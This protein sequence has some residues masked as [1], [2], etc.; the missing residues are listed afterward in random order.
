M[1]RFIWILSLIW[2][3]SYNLPKS[4]SR[5]HLIHYVPH[6]KFLAIDQMMLQYC[7][8]RH[9]KRDLNEI[10]TSDK[11]QVAQTKEW[12]RSDMEIDYC[13]YFH[14]MMLTKIVRYP[15]V[16]LLRCHLCIIRKGYI[17]GLLWV[18]FRWYS[19]SI[20]IYAGLIMKMNDR[21]KQY[22]GLYFCIFSLIERQKHF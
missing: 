5:F 9:T 7:V 20:K 3:I 18:N 2:I 19:S 4:M 22:N 6:N 8:V 21:F 11:E 10:V 13:P 15:K 12:M 16:F 14:H 17:V 1:K